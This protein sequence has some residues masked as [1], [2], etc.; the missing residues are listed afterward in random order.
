[1]K[2]CLLGLQV[3]I[4]LPSV[5]RSNRLSSSACIS[6]NP[7]QVESG[8]RDLAYLHKN[9]KCLLGPRSDRTQSR[10]I[11]PVFAGKSHFSFLPPHT[12]GV[13]EVTYIHGRSSRASYPGCPM[14]HIAPAGA[15]R[16]VLASYR[17]AFQIS[18]SSCT[19]LTSWFSSDD[20]SL[21][22]NHFFWHTLASCVAVPPGGRDFVQ[23]LPEGA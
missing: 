12:E 6:A 13:A 15:W 9:S 14:Q 16:L 20:L 5:I 18:L 17:E 7:Y 3:R 1:M 21:R 4:W 11:L 10:S 23:S 22:K 8:K 2:L 19:C